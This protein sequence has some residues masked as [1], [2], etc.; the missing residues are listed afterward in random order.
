MSGR[1]VEAL[2]WSVWI[3]LKATP[4]D[5]NIFAVLKGVEGGLESALAYITPWTRNI[6]PNLDLQDEPF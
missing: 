1:V 6:R 5:A 2:M 4:C 3:E